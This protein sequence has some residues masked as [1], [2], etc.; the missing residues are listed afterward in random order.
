VPGHTHF[1]PVAAGR[2]LQAADGGILSPRA[3]LL[4]AGE[5]GTMAAFQRALTGGFTRV[6]PLYGRLGRRGRSADLVVAQAP[7][8]PPLHHMGCS[9]VDCIRS[10]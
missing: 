2:V 9:P 7:A 1:P 6:A 5:V 3:E 8:W 10:I 4:Q